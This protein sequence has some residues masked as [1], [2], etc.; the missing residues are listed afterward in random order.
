MSTGFSTACVKVLRD[1][2][3]GDE[4]T[5]YYGDDFFGDANCKCE[6]VT[7]ERRGQ[8]SFRCPDNTKAEKKYSF[9][10]TSKR[11]KRDTHRIRGKIF[12]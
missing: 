1:I 7:C 9:R 2:D 6:C 10:D 11:L 4:I 3:E 12:I 5:C 8:G